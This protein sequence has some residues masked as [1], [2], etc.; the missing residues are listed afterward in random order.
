MKFL[1]FIAILLLSSIGARG[2]N[3]PE[4]EVFYKRGTDKAYYVH[5]VQVKETLYAVSKTYGCKVKK[6]MKVNKLESHALTPGQRL[7]I[8]FVNEALIYEPP[9]MEEDM[10]KVYYKVKR[11]ETAF[12]ICRSYFHVNLTAIKELN[13]LER[14]TL[15][16]GQRLLIGYLSTYNSFKP[17]QDPAVS[18]EPLP[19]APPTPPVQIL[20]DVL[21]PDIE[22]V[23]HNP[24]EDQLYSINFDNGVA[25][26]NKQVQGLNGYFVLHRFA[27]RNSWIEVTNPMYDTSIR[28]RVI[29]NIPDGSYPED[30]LIVVSPSIAKDLGALDERFYVKVR[31]LR[32][33]T[34]LTKGK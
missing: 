1:A 8:P 3:A 27:A 13:D 12:R 28:A 32:A 24:E 20:E 2:A 5:H 23:S 31:Y 25:Y 17:V 11:K 21:D 16:T 9:L 6:I 29:G 15:K 18:I 34:K 14:N 7:I 30:V 10:I 4:V 33:E 19:E 26:W 22:I